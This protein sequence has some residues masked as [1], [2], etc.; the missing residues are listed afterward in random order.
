MHG[1]NSNFDNL[2]K[3]A[4]REMRSWSMVILIKL[5]L[6][7]IKHLEVV[8]DQPYWAHA[9]METPC[10]IAD[11]QA[12]KVTIIAGNQ[13]A[14][15]VMNDLM[16]VLPGYTHDQFDVTIMRLGSGFGRKFIVDAVY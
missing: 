13:T 8:Y 10:G 3:N 1:L 9:T 4:D 12:D 2:I 15:R 16:N 14:V 6:R 7:L 11:V 5:M